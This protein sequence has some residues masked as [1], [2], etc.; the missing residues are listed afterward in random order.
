MPNL[1]PNPQLFPAANGITPEC[2]V[3]P[4]SLLSG[5]IPDI[6][7]HDR[8]GPARRLQEI[9]RY[10]GCRLGGLLRGSVALYG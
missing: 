1:L 4:Q 6:V 3:T 5:E 7:F 2:L 9:R 8:E 10:V